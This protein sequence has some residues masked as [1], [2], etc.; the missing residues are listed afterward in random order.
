MWHRKSKT[1]P[2]RGRRRKRS[3]KGRLVDLSALKR[4]L[5]LA[6]LILFVGIGISAYRKFHH[7]HSEHEPPPAF[8]IRAVVL[9][10]VG[11]A[12][13]AAE[14]RT[15]LRRRFIDVVKIGDT[16]MMDYEKTVVIDRGGGAA[17]LE[18]VAWL[19]GDVGIA[20]TH[21]EV[22]KS[23]LPVDVTVIVG[24]DYARLFPGGQKR[25]WICP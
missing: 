6:L 20:Q 1:R 14:V 4:L 2:S 18:Y 7:R 24:L 3:L 11:K 21:L 19:L 25:W 13:L 22:L 23:D 10:G 16:D 17:K 15:E 8:S 12:G 9:N 5:L